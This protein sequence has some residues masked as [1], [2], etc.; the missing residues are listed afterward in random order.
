M[1]NQ[2][3]FKK[4][5]VGVDGSKDSFKAMDYGVRLALATRGYLTFLFVITDQFIKEHYRMDG[6]HH[7]GSPVAEVM[8]DQARTEELGRE[9]FDR[10]EAEASKVLGSDNFTTK[11]RAGD[12]R[13]EFVQELRKGQYD[14]CILGHS[15]ASKS[16]ETVFGKIS[17][18]IFQ[19]TNVPI[20]ITKLATPLR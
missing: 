13:E 8:A 3:I 2:E 19:E 20:L 10:V 6:D 9:V 17:D 11:T 18:A 1:D 4:I 12:P 5:L 15:G 14:L 7:G 16:F